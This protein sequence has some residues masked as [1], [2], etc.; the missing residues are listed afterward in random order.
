MRDRIITDEAEDQNTARIR[1][2]AL[3][4][5]IKDHII[6]E[7]QISIHFLE[8]I[9]SSTQAI[10]YGVANSQALI[11]AAVSAA[12]EVAPGVSI[13]SEIQVVQEYNIMP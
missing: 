13:Q 6:Y 5:Q 10:L 9:V 12:R 4:Q 8:A 3:G 7:R 11:E 2:L 1:E